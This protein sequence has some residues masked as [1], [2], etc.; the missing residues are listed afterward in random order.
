MSS[1][2]RLQQK[3]R[4]LK[5]TMRRLRYRKKL[6]L[7]S[8]FAVFV[9]SIMVQQQVMNIHYRELLDTIAQGESH[10]NYNAYY[11]NAA[12]TLIKFT[13]MTVGE[14]G[15]WQREYVAAGHASSA[16]GKYQIIDSTLQSLVET[17]CIRQDELFDA[18][19]QD[20]MAIELVN[21]RGAKQYVRGII[22][23]EEFA[24]N[25]SKEWAA[26]PRIIG[27]KPALSYYDG[28]G[29]NRSRISIDQI[30][31]AIDTIHG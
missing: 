19:L 22:T 20:R 28:D 12:N 30:L 16:V 18:E 23:R 15:A 21:R 31:A 14:V 27:D 10:G 25:L 13:D 29:I 4:R 24:H 26:L 5:R 17:M 9:G 6:T 2:H 7:V 1:T 3:L 11:G 8:L